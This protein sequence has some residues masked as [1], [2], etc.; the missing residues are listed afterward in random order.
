MIFPNLPPEVEAKILFLRACK[1]SFYSFL[2]CKH[3]Y[4]LRIGKTPAEATA[5]TIC[6]LAEHLMEAGNCC[7][8]EWRI[9]Y[10]ERLLPFKRRDYGWFNGQLKV[11]FVYATPSK[12][13][14]PLHLAAGHQQIMRSAHD[15]VV[16]F[17]HWAEPEGWHVQ[18]KN[19]GPFSSKEFSPNWKF[20]PD[21]I[22]FTDTRY[23]F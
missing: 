1:S 20:E 8:D 9:L 6:C 13:L 2:G 7:E 14:E 15:V 22:F 23:Q 5:W 17:R 4:Q 19:C 10:D 3:K 21:V 12:W 18:F 16:F 11:D